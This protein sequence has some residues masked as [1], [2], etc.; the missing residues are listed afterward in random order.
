MGYFSAL[1]LFLFVEFYPILLIY[2]LCFWT[3]KA[4]SNTE[5]KFDI[6]TGNIFQNEL[7]IE[8]IISSQFP[9]NH[10]ASFIVFRCLNG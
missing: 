9:P 6:M 7:N 8:G 1:I 5:Y 10:S 2:K 3:A 4:A